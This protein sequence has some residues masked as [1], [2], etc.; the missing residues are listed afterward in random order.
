MTHRVPEKLLPSGKGWELKWDEDRQQP[1][2]KL[3]GTSPVN[4]ARVHELYISGMDAMGIFFQFG[5]DEDS[6]SE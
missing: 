5:P 3:R 6:E 2:L 4:D 1:Y